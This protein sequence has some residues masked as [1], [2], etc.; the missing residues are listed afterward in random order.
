M[1][2]RPDYF[3]TE[4]KQDSKNVIFQSWTQAC[5]GSWSVAVLLLCTYGTELAQQLGAH[6]NDDFHGGL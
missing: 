4:L 5:V 2:D 1:C 6:P 3:N